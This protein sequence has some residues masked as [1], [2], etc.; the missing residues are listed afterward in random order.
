MKYFSNGA[1]QF[2]GVIRSISV[3]GIGV[4]FY[5]HVHVHDRSGINGHTS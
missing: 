4:L 5:V 3:L 1:F 2:V